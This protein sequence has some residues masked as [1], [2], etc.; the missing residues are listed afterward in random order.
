MSAVVDNAIHIKIE[1]VEFRYPILCNELRDGGIPL[2]HPSEKLN[3]FFSWSG[4]DQGDATLP[5]AHPL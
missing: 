3:N 4:L 1:R 2:T 5:L